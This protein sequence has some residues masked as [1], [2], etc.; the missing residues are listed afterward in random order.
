MINLQPTKQFTMIDSFIERQSRSEFLF[1]QAGS[2]WHLYTPGENSRVVF[3]TEEDYSFGMTLCGI[4]KASFPKLSIY[5][6]ALMSNHVHFILSGE[7]RDCSSFFG[8]FVIRLKLYYSRQQKIVDLTEFSKSKIQIINDLNSLR[9]EI[10]YVNRNGF[11][12][13]PDYS[14]FS[15]RWGASMFYFNGFKDIVQ[16]RSFNDLLF[17]EKRR[18]CHCRETALPETYKVI[19]NYISPKSYCDIQTGMDFF[20]NAQQYCFLLFKNQEANS[21]IAK[22]LGDTLFVTDEEMFGIVLEICRKEY[23]VKSVYQLTNSSK[24]ELAKT[25]RFKYNATKKQIRRFLK[26]E[27]PVLDELFGPGA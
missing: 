8:L 27:H 11:L 22:R 24:I 20:L 23:D 16:E 18:L 5:A 13:C 17:D 15:Y 10:A 14:P 3:E 1:L 6:F 4:C 26:I 25:L 19:Y 9:N 21:N 7:E 2:I 12:V